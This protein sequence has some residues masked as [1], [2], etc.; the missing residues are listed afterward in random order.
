MNVFGILRRSHWRQPLVALLLAAIPLQGVAADI[1]GGCAQDHPHALAVSAIDHTTSVAHSHPRDMSDH[2]PA[3]QAA[4]VKCNSCAPCCA[5]AAFPS[6]M[7]IPIA[8]AP[9]TFEF[10]A[11]PGRHPSLFISYFYRPPKTILA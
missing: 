7:T 9:A 4:K 8:S 3:H 2:S 10:R 11:P 6:S 1:M 5:G